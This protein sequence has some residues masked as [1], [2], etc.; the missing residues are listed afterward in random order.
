LTKQ[1]TEVK[2]NEAKIKKEEKIITTAIFPG[3]YVQGEGALE[4]LGEEIL[5]FGRKAF[6]ICDPFVMDNIYPRIEDKV[7]KRVEIRVERF[8]SECSDEEIERLFEI[9]EK[10]A[11]EVVGGM[12]GG[13]TLDTAKA[14]AYRLKVPVFIIPTIASTD[15]P[16]SALSVI[17]TPEG[18]FKRYLKLPKN[19]DLVLVDTKVIANAPVRFLVSGMGDA[20]ATWFEAESCKKAYAKNMAGG[21]GT[22]SA[23]SLARLCYETLIEYG[24]SAKISCERK[25]VTPALEHI[26]E[27]NILLSGVGFES[28]G[29][30]AAHAIHDGLTVLEE[31]HKYFHGE[32]VAIGTL[33]SLFLTDKPRKIIDEVFSFCELVGLPT[34]LGDIGLYNIRE[35]KLM[36]VAEAA[37]REDETIHNEP[38]PVTPQMVFSALKTADGEGKRRKKVK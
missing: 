15:A 18:K 19:P 13:K 38:F 17:Y 31:T 11:C 37:C 7:R 4:N 10:N 21:Y 9:G 35:E 32:K 26:V 33:A 8:G 22:L 27:A 23:Y 5:R 16:C 1:T 29:L 14:V 3:R 24:L 28:G 36:K 20:L 25:I 6:L 34:T 30:A 2:S 12:G